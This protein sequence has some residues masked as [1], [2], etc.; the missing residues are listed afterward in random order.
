MVV[1]CFFKLQLKP[2][3]DP[4]ATKCLFVGYSSCQ[5]GYKCFSSNTKKF[6][7]T[8]DVTFFEEKS[9]YPKS[10]FLGKSISKALLW[11][12]SLEPSQTSNKLSPPC[13]PV[14]FLTNQQLPD[15]FQPVAESSMPLTF[16]NLVEPYLDTG[17]DLFKKG[18]DLLTYSRRQ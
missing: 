8:M 3:L 11:D 6:F 4:K 9:Y 14:L 1:Q 7:I 13:Q 12:F 15:S 2:S 18:P 16:D 17:R 10:S 5:K